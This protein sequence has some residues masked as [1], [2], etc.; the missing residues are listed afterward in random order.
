MPRCRYSLIA[1]GNDNHTDFEQE[2]LSYLELLNLCDNAYISVPDKR[3]CSV[4]N[5]DGDGDEILTS[6]Q[7]TRSS[8]SPVIGLLRPM[9][10]EKLE[11]ENARRREMGMRE[12]WEMSTGR[13]SFSGWVEGW[14]GRT[15]VMK[16][17]CERWRD[18]EDFQEVCG[19][20]K[21]RGE[22]Y[23]VYKDPFGVHDHPSSGKEE[24]ELNFAFEMERSACALFGVVTYGVHMSIYREEQGQLSVWVP[25]RAASKPT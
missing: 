23:A 19:R 6:F 5:K 25:T 11:K 22:A 10:V 8:T 2:M 24:E 15:E 16:E 4:S 18:E 9:I 3:L 17:M 13:V 12:V 1:Y 14:R 21:W 20:D 7:L